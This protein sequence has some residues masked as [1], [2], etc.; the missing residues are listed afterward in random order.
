M[1]I[2][3]LQTQWNKY[4]LS[5]YLGQRQTQLYTG[6]LSLQLLMLPPSDNNIDFQHRHPHTAKITMS[7]GCQQVSANDTLINDVN[8]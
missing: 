7:K 3:A 8:T 1:Q 6:N 5:R 4:F 2:M